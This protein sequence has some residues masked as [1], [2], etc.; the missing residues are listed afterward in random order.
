VGAVEGD[1]HAVE[2]HGLSLPRSSALHIRCLP[3]PAPEDY[4]PGPGTTDVTA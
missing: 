4:V 3:R 2:A 1:D